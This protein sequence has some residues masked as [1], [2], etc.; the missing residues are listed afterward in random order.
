MFDF[1]KKNSS[2]NQV[3]KCMK[4]ICANYSQYRKEN[5]YNDGSRLIFNPSIMEIFLKDSSKTLNGLPSSELDEC[6]ANEITERLAY[7][8]L[9]DA[10][11]H[12]LAA[13]RRS[14]F[15]SLSTTPA[16]EAILFVKYL[17]DKELMGNY[18]TAE[19]HKEIDDWIQQTLQS[20]I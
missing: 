12:R 18:I 6:V 10:A 7:S 2:K 8:I 11:A 19:K 13:G 15:F 16:A 14:D 4:E 9:M 5:Q 1:L 3:T 20:A 17:C